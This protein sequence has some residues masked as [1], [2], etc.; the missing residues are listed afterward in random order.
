[1]LTADPVHLGNVVHNLLDNA[2]KYTPE[3]P[4]IRVT[5]RIDNGTLSLAITDNG[6]GM[7]QDDCRRAFD[8]YF[9]VSTGNVH[10]VK[11]FGLGLSYVKLMV[12][13]HGGAVT[14]HS[15][16]GEGTRVEV[17]FPASCLTDGGSL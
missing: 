17:T 3:S 5:T 14:I 2:S 15:R 12:E 8:K 1:M 4:R 16:P 6:I 7:H 13:A 11:G 9:R 10:D